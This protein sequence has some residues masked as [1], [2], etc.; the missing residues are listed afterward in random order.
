MFETLVLRVVAWVTLIV[1]LLFA[2]FG[3]VVSGYS[4]LFTV[5]YVLGALVSWAVILAFAQ[6]VERAVS[7]DQRLEAF[8]RERRR[9]LPKAPVP[10]KRKEPGAWGGVSYRKP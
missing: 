10:P 5:P 3:L 9:P 4:L 8:E 6:L 2:L 1:P 7:I